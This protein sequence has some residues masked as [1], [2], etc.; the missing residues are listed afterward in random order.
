MGKAWRS[1]NLSKSHRGLVASLVGFE[2]SGDRDL[3]CAP[4]WGH[5]SPFCTLLRLETPLCTLARAQLCPHARVRDTVMQKQLREGNNT[6]HLGSSLPQ[7]SL[8][9]THA[10]KGFEQFWGFTV[11]TKSTSPTLPVASVTLLQ[12]SRCFAKSQNSPAD[13]CCRIQRAAGSH[14]TAGG[15][16]NC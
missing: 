2:R 12:A 4:L 5:C 14:F 3:S 15:T 1:I 6:A 7:R 10:Q 13:K 8:T 16:F 9:P 11:P